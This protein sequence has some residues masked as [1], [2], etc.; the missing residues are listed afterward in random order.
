MDKRVVAGFKAGH[1]HTRWLLIQAAV[2]ILRRRPPLAEDLRTWAA[3]IARAAGN[4]WPWSPSPVASPASSMRCCEMAACSSPNA[5]DIRVIPLLRSPPLWACDRVALLPGDA[6]PG[7][8]QVRWVGER[9][10]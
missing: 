7:L 1:S 8:S 6:G 2:S 9:E 10:C 3:R 4:R 5:F